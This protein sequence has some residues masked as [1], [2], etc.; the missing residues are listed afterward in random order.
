MLL[1]FFLISFISCELSPNNANEQEIIIAYIQTDHVIVNLNQPVD[2]LPQN[3][4][5]DVQVAIEDAASNVPK[6][7]M[8]RLTE[9]L[10][11]HSNRVLQRY[12]CP[13]YPPMDIKEDWKDW[14]IFGKKVMRNKDTK[15]AQVALPYEQHMNYRHETSQLAYIKYKLKTKALFFVVFKRYF[16]QMYDVNEKV[17]YAMRNILSSFLLFLSAAGCFFGLHELHEVLP[18]SLGFGDDDVKWYNRIWR[19]TIGVGFIGIPGLILFLL[20]VFAFSSGILIAKSSNP[21]VEIEEIENNA[22][23]NV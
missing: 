12:A 23:S 18:G 11:A 13:N 16:D 2:P 17:F 20:G 1:I 3:D 10:N 9:R 4:V 19:S 8:V 21:G 6:S 5:I 7:W 15:F 22:E 14:K